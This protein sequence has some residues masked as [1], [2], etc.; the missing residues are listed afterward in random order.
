MI[1]FTANRLQT[2][3]A[4]LSELIAHANFYFAHAPWIFQLNSAMLRFLVVAA[5]LDPF[6]LQERSMALSNME[7]L[8]EFIFK[9]KAQPTTAG[10]V[11]SS[12]EEL[13]ISAVSSADQADTVLLL[14]VLVECLQFVLARLN[15]GFS[16]L[17]S[18]SSARRGAKFSRTSIA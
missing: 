9:S 7:K 16:Q 5:S 11:A 3:Q 17:S 2:T 18:S 4:C 13:D 14:P 8:S 12:L 6:S 10:K 1:D 15:A